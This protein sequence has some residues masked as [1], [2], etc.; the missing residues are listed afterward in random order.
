LL[1]PNGS[2][3]QART[4]ASSKNFGDRGNNKTLKEMTNP[5]LS[6]VYNQGYDA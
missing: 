5:F 3:V 1:A 6:K 2:G 4:I